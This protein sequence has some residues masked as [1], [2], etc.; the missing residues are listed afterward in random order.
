VLAEAVELDVLH[1]HHLGHV[2]GEHALADDFGRALI[3]ALRQLAQR[4]RDALGRA[5]ESFARGILADLDEQLAD[6][7]AQLAVVGP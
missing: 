2:L 7:L 4:P 3:L 1:Q 6:E 5:R